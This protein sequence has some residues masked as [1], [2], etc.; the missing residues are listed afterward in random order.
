MYYILKYN[1]FFKLDIVYISNS[2]LDFTFFTKK[3]FG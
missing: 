3:K 1:S 2:N